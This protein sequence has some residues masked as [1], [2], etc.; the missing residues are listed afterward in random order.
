MDPPA[1]AIPER[2]SDGVPGAGF[3]P[4]RPCGQRIL[5]PPCL[6]FHHPGVGRQG[7]RSHVVASWPYDPRRRA[8]PGVHAATSLVLLLT[9]V[10][11]GARSRRGPGRLRPTPCGCA[12]PGSPPTRAPRAA[13]TTAVAADGTMTPRCPRR[14]PARARSTAS[15]C[16]P[17]SACSRRSTRPST[18][19]RTR[20]AWRSRRR[21]ATRRSARSTRRCTASSRSRAIG[22]GA[23]ADAAAIAYGDVRDAWRD[24]LAHDN[25]GRG[26]VLIGH[27]QG[28]GMLTQLVKREIDN[29][30]EGPQAARRGVPARRQRRRAEGPRR[31]RRLRARPGV[32][33]ADRRPAASSRSPRSTRPPPADAIFGR[34]DGGVQPGARRGSA[35]EAPRS[36][37]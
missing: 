13:P 4:A 16:T 11:V 19:S 10:L 36:S 9:T 21:R 33:D 35:G 15:T 6:P 7:R 30:A 2:V 31:R 29:E 14:S 1:D 17:P 3:E 27:S 32:P 5:S 34:V 12:G 8:E 26:V 28:A 22:G 37:A 25:H 23:T 18:S 20:P 24:Y